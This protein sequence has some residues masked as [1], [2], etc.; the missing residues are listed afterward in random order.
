MT[1]HSHKD[2]Q[3]KEAPEIKTHGIKQRD[4]EAQENITSQH[5]FPDLEFVIKGF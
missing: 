5:N 1:P 2:I 4:K 3:S